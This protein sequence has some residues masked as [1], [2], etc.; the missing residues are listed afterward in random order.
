MVVPRELNGFFVY[1]SS[2][3]NAFTHQ[4]SK[5]PVELL[6][7]GLW[8]QHKYSLEIKQVHYSGIVMLEIYRRHTISLDFRLQSTGQ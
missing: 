3:Q 7:R 8:A 6:S 1:K 5:G 2:H 4:S